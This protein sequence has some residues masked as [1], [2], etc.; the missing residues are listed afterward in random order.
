[1][2]N[3]SVFL[4]KAYNGRHTDYYT[5]GLSELYHTCVMHNTQRL[6]WQ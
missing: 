1:M 5:A 3:A 6:I 4:T 2:T